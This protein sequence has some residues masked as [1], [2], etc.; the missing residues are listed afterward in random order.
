M[1]E[2]FDNKDE[3]VPNE[4]FEALTPFFTLSIGSGLNQVLV[5]LNAMTVVL[6]NTAALTPENTLKLLDAITAFKE[7]AQEVSISEFMRTFSE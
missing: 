7:V 1:T 3:Q 5:K 6:E 2:P 4:A